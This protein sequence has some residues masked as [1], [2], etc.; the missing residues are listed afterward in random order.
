MNAEYKRVDCNWC[1]KNDG[2]INNLAI[3]TLIAEIDEAINHCNDYGELEDE[4]EMIRQLLKK[5]G[6]G[7]GE[8]TQKDIYKTANFL[9]GKG[10]SS[11]TVRYELRHF[12]ETD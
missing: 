11:E 8:V 9:M 7:A 4:H 6:F 10:F 2:I 1:E 3:L 12:L 5:R